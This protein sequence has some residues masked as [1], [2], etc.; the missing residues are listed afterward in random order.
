MAV[1]DDTA[2]GQDGRRCEGD[3][4]NGGIFHGN[5]DC[6]RRGEGTAGVTGR[7][8]PVAGLAPA[9]GISAIDRATAAEEA[10]DALGNKGGRHDARHADPPRMMHPRHVVVGPGLPHQREG[11]NEDMPLDCIAPGDLDRLGR[12]PAILEGEPARRLV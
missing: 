3:G 7:E 12:R 6:G 10:L 5:G 11:R 4:R 9:C 2:G 1:C 8:R